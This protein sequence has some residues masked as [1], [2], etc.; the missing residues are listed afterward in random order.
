MIMLSC[1][2]LAGAAGADV[3][4]LK[5]GER[6][7]GTIRDAL[8]TEKQVVIS[9]PV[10]GGTQVR[11][12]KRA[13]IRRIDRAGASGEAPGADAIDADPNDLQ[14]TKGDASKSTVGYVHCIGGKAGVVQPA[15]LA[16]VTAKGLRDA[17][18]AKDDLV[19]LH[20]DGASFTPAETL[21]IL[22]VIKDALTQGMADRLVAYVS[23]A[24]GE[25]SLLALACPNIVCAPGALL[26]SPTPNAFAGHDGARVI[27][28]MKEICPQRS[29]LID[30][31][32]SGIPVVY[33]A[34]PGWSSENDVVRITPVRGV[35][36][37]DEQTAVSSG[38]AQGTAKSLQAVHLSLARGGNHEYKNRTVGAQGGRPPRP[39][40]ADV[41]ER[42]KAMEK[43]QIERL[44]GRYNKGLREVKEGIEIFIGP[45]PSY[46]SG[47]FQQVKDTWKSGLTNRNPLTNDLKEK[48]SDAIKLILGG[49]TDIENT[50]RRYEDYLRRGHEDVRLR[51]A[52]DALP[53]IQGL[54]YALSQDKNPDGFESK[55]KAVHKLDPL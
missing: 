39:P 52:V 12:I 5:S 23:D 28:L 15:G 35:L 14:P 6:I 9:E 45:G 50:A 7:E 11:F 44:A 18:D 2:V 27:T 47:I 29:V 46:S 10:V 53:K 1:L 17:L 33:A 19:V 4:V 26:K 20:L 21:E 13:D 40:A 51:V 41:A 22:E 36:S 25:S 37:V 48:Q 43:V 30:A 16:G 8:C 34:A 3:V 24:S 31:F 38:L 49:I 32:C 55:C 42:Q 54:N